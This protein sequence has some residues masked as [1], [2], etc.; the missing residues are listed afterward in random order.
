MQNEWIQKK[1]GFGKGAECALS[2][3]KGLVFP[4]HVFTIDS[5]TIHFM[6]M[7]AAFDLLA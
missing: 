7:E 3:L 5:F 4:E 1:Q 2:K 6:S